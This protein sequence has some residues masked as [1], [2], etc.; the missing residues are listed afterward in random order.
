MSAPYRR[1]A[2]VWFADIVGFTTLSSEDEPES[3][4]VVQHFEAAV[5]DAVSRYGGTLVK[6]LGDGAMVHFPST[7]AAVKAALDLRT[8][9]AGH[10]STPLRIGV[11]VGDVLIREDADLLGDG[12][13]VAARLQSAAGP[14]EILVSEEVWR[15]LRHLRVFRFAALGPQRLKGLAERRTAYSVETDDDPARPAAAAKRSWTWLNAGL[16]GAIVIAAIVAFA[17]G[18]TKHRDT[19]DGAEPGPTVRSLVVLP[20]DDLG[21][22]EEQEYFVAGMHDALIGE[23]T[24]IESLR[25][26]SRTSAIRYRDAQQS[27]AD[28][29]RE[30]NVEAVV[31]ASVLR[32]GDDVR[33]R[34]ELIQVLPDEVSLWAGTFDRELRNVLALHSDLARALADAIRIRLTP[35]ESADL[36]RNQTVNPLAFEAYQRGRAQWEQHTVGALDRALHYFQLALEHDPEYAP[37]YAGIASVW[38]GR[39]QIGAAQPAHASREAKR[40]ALRALSIDNRLARAHHVLAVEFG[41]HDWDWDSS[42]QHFRQALELNPGDSGIRSFY[43]MVLRITGRTDEALRQS[44]QAALEDPFNPIVQAIHASN[45]SQTGKVGEAVARYR[46]ILAD[47]PVHPIVLYDFQVVLHVAGQF[48]ASYDAS[49]ALYAAENDDAMIA[50]LDAGHAEGGYAAAMRAAAE[51][52]ATRAEREY[53]PPSRVAQFFVRAGDYEAALEWIDRMITTRDP[54]AAY[55][56]GPIYADLRERPRFQ[57]ALQSVNL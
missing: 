14:G 29:A 25:V 39:R 11:H 13:N 55:L 35:G 9:F 48:E 27:L 6:F 15:Q 57:A 43:S 50:A 16:A 36:T 2:A 52:L 22:D 28:I 44:S 21:N 46:E 56:G 5:R 37:A 7:E 4:R 40:A 19:A 49:R 42:E 30:L 24:K 31:A 34:A 17:V 41:W 32:S 18:G 10:V 26:I 47:S 3:L 45:L 54:S 12:V 53:I 23:L 1:L 8:A 33:I 51:V 20:F 38:Y